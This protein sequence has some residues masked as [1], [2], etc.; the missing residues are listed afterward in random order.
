MQDMV[1]CVPHLNI[2]P[3][4][5]SLITSCFP[6]VPRFKSGAFESGGRSKFAEKLTVFWSE[7]IPVP[8]QAFFVLPAG[9]HG[10]SHFEQGRGTPYTYFDYNASKMPA[11]PG[12]AATLTTTFEC[13]P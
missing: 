1:V 11:L 8:G 13:T 5:K 7:S 10:P 9:L 2:Q 6:C 4:H 3:I 12:E